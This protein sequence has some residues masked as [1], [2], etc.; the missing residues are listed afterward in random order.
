MAILS[1]C[2]SPKAGVAISKA[3]VEADGEKWPLAVESGYLDCTGSASWFQ[4]DDGK[5]YRLN[6]GAH[7]NDYADLKAIW[8]ED[9][10]IQ[11]QVGAAFPGQMPPKMWLSIGGLI[12]RANKLCAS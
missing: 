2:S 12:D 3:E 10:E 9:R 5:K 11:E 8:L 4:T 7:M 1:N 6:G